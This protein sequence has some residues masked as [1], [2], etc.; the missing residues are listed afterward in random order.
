MP[1]NIILTSNAKKQL[2]KINNPYLTKIEKEINKLA[3]NP[4]PVNS[5]KIVGQFNYY[6]LRVN[7]YRILYTVF[8][9]ELQIDVIDIGTRQNYYDNIYFY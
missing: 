7:D 3:T 2:S 9:K 8:E 6:R 5:V 1:Y 4:F